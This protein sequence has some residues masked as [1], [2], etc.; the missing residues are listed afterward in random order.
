MA[1][2]SFKKE[3]LETHNAYRALH[4]AP[5]LEYNDELNEAAQ[6]WADHCLKKM[7]LGHSNTDDGENVFYS[8][9]TRI[10]KPTGKEAV[11]AWYG[12]IKD[13]DFNKPEH[14]PGTGHFTQVVWK[15]SK[16]LGVGLATDGR[17]V[18]VVG[19]YREA[20]N[21]T[22]PGYYEKNVLPKGNKAI[23]ARCGENK[24]DDLSKPG[25]QP[26]TDSI[27]KQNT[28]D[29]S[30][31]KEFLETHNAYRALHHAPPLEY[32]DELNEA[33]QKWA[34]HCLKKMTLGHSN[35]DDGENVF[36]SQSTRIVKP[37]GKEAVD[38][39]YGEIKDYDFS[40][41]QHQPGTGH[42]TQVVWKSSKELG[43]GLATDGR[44]VFVVGQYR[45]AGNVTN[46]G[47][48]EKN[49]L[50]KGNK[51]IDARCGENKDDD[52]SKPGNQPKTD[53]INK[54]NTLDDSFKKEFLE[55]HNAYRALHHAP[56][57]E[58]ND[59]LNEAAQ[60]W[61]DHCLKKMTLGHSKT[62]DG[63]NVFYSQSTRIVKPTGKEAVDAWYG[64]IKDYD[65]S[66][67]QHQP[68][69]G[70]FTQ[71]VWKSS[72]ELGVGLATDGRTVFVVGQYREAGNVT[73]PGYYEKNVLPKGN[74]AIDA[75]CGENKDDDLSKPG[76]QPKTDSI[77]KQNT[78]D[79]S[80]KK[81]F[82]ETH[83]AYR[84]LHHAPPLEY[85]DELNEAAQKWADHCLKKMTLGHS[86]TD[87]GENVFYSQSTRI[88]KP[89]GKEAV[90]AWYGEIKDYDF[91][92]PQHQPGTGHFT[93]VVWK[94]SKELGVGLATDGRTVFVVGQYREAGNVTNPGY[95]EKNVLP[96]GN[97]AIDA[98]CG[99]NKDDDLSKPGNQPKTDSI[100][101]QNT[102]DASFKK[103]FLET[104]NAYRA[105]HHAPPLEYNDELNEAAQK[106]A[107]HC[108][109][110]MTLGHSKTDDG[111][112]VFYSQSTRIVKPTGKEAVDAWYGEIKDYDF[113][114][115]QHQPR[116]G[117][118]TQVVWKSSK[119]LGVGLA[120]DGRTVFVVGQYRE[121]GNVTNPGYY[122]KNVLPKD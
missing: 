67:P 51:A 122:E 108:L 97:K 111:E 105:L 76:N 99:E 91:S 23:D 73:N 32:N 75:R 68:G 35:T 90:D 117:H 70:H 61:A 4:H 31:K 86:K 19:Q 84:A 56:P 10:V 1:D 38:A 55:T 54:Q 85:N 103:E 102:L 21:N 64:E 93:Q 92:K 112:N 118:F 72:K 96:K 78:L 27:N 81:E 39:W 115:P 106:W 82:L 66:K 49:V 16:E 87:D 65:F 18:F 41:P 53:S 14:Q 58:Y 104:H 113:S 80:F 120:T 42:F 11:D 119:E 59:E 6:K 48:Y 17:T 77:N 44:T 109:K 100:N 34:D 98:R 46:P 88:V 3:F 60:K 52:L 7:T 89:T 37:T 47:Y 121:A 24:D 33:A 43:V 15:S 40:K 9:S 28:L 74:K 20:G 95:Y 116:T 110:K 107:D 22:N 12:E 25:N 8:Q 69:T 114:K 79:D 29:D 63:E 62:D 36:Y 83:N 50:P 30:F 5:P 101:K 2:A 94:S 26:K 13:Y 45:E 57:L 71:V